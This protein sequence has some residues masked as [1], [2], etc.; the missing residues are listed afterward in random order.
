MTRSLSWRAL[1]ALVLAQA[2]PVALMLPAEHVHFADGEQHGA[3][4][5][6]RHVALHDNHAD[7]HHDEITLSHGEEH[8]TW[9]PEVFLGQTTFA[10]AAPPATVETVQSIGASIVTTPARRPAHSARS[11]GPPRSPQPLRGPPTLPA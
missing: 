6:H 11:H 3:A 4:I 2:V 9:L 1:I 10:P 5:V 8:V 7:D